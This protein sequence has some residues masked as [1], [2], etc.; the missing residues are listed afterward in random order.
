MTNAVPIAAGFVLFDE[1]LPRDPRGALQIA[2]FASIVV[3]AALLGRSAAG[4]P[5]PETAAVD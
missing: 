3:S 5:V 2:A 4:K 1:T